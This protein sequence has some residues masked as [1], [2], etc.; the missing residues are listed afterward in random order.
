MMST[1]VVSDRITS[2]SRRWF[3]PIARF[4]L[5]VIFFLFGFLKLIGLSPADELALNF[6]N[7]MGFGPYFDVLF[8]GL[9]IAECIIG[10]LFL[11]PKLTILA[12]ILMIA[13]L[14]FVSSPI[15]LFTAGTWE[16]L[17]VPNLSGQ[18][19]IKNLALVALALGLIA[20]HSN[21]ASQKK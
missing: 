5:F 15:I 19:I 3:E 9:A 20:M 6:T 13:H 2:L 14:A 4:A 17:F 11:I 1:H 10:L 12:S 16:S 18:Y 8:F 7:H 21:T